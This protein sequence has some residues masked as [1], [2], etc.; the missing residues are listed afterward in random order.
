MS[1]KKVHN[2]LKG[3]AVTGATVGGASVLGDA[4]LAFAAELGEEQAL[5]NA[6]GTIV[7][8]ATQEQAKQVV[9]TTIEQ[10]TNEAAHE[11]VKEEDAKEI[12]DEIEAEYDAC[13]VECH[14]GGQ[15]LYYY[16]IS[17]E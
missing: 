1:K 7:I 13:D 12:A 2:L 4:N 5:A 6:D 17:V 16:L 10:T 15:P 14:N 8:E 11:D 9:E 3:V